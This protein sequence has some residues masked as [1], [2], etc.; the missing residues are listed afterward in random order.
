MKAKNVFFLILAVLFLSPG[1][2]FAI[3]PNSNAAATARSANSANAN[4]VAASEKSEA[5]TIKNCDK[6]QSRI[7]SKNKTFGNAKAAHSQAYDNLLDRLSKFSTNIKAK[8]YDTTDLDR[9]I[10]TL[11]TKIDEFK[12]IID[13]TYALMQ[14]TSQGICGKT[15]PDALISLAQIRNRMRLVHQKAAEIRTFYKSV[16]KEDLLEIKAQSPG[17]VSSSSQSETDAETAED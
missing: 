6:I 12:L 5:N 11:K 15:K 10:A 3:S 1:T 17:A 13:Q 7:D 9:D 4:A 2:V 14:Q 16:I 8:G